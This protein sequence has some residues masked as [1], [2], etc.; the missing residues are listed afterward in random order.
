MKVPMLGAGSAGAAGN[1]AWRSASIDQ[2]AEYSPSLALARVLRVPLVPVVYNVVGT[3]TSASPTT[4]QMLSWQ[5]NNEPTRLSQ[6]AVVDSVMFE[7]DCASA[8]AGTQL[9]PLSDFF[10]G[11]QSGIGAMLLV[12]GNPQYSVATDLLT[13]LRTLCAMLNEGWPQGWVLGPTQGIMMQFNAQQVLPFLP[14]TVTVSFRMWTPDTSC[15]QKFVNL[16]DSDALC[17]L[18]SMGYASAGPSTPNAS[19]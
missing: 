10:F 8:N 3:F 9:K 1:A 6:F 5:A 19:Q 17:E 11:L 4:T 14:V 13:P 7:I 16:S 18:Q 12:K 15:G 2:V